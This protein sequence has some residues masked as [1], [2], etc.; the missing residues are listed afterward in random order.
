[1]HEPSSSFPMKQLASALFGPQKIMGFFGR[2]STDRLVAGHP[3]LRHSTVKLTHQCGVAP[4]ADMV[5]A[6]LSKISIIADQRVENG[7]GLSTG[8]LVVV[9]VLSLRVDAVLPSVIRIKEVFRHS[10]D[11]RLPT[12]TRVVA[13]VDDVLLSD[14]AKSVDH[15]R[16]RGAAA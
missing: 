1:M 5:A 14:R 13:R 10:S 12:S 8:F 4:D 11:H 16:C 2:N 9:Q 7:I 15:G 6:I 3:D